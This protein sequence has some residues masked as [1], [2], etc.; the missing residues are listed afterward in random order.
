[1]TTMKDLVADTRRIAYGSMS[2]QLNF[3]SA[4]T[5]AGADELFMT[6]DLGAIAP[7]MVLSCGLNVYY[8]TGA[9]AAEKK[10][11]VYPG[12]DNSPTGILTA[13]SPVMIRP[14]V[15][16]WLLFNNVN[17]VI[18]QMSSSTFGLYREASWDATVDPTWQTYP[19]P[20]VAQSMTALIK[21]Q[22]RYPGSDDTWID[23]PANSVQWQPENNLVRM[24]RGYPSGTDMRFFYRAAFV[25]GVSLTTDV[26]VTCGLAASMTDIPPLGAA[27]ALLRTTESR[28]SQ[29]HAQGD[30][31]RSEEVVAMG[32]AQAAREL[33]RDFKSRVNDEYIRLLNRNPITRTI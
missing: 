20:T 25:E 6:M 19:I 10:V 1:M 4:D 3:L 16:D 21:V 17:D 24:T 28:R 8:V 7:G 33:D 5:T 18:R 15:T 13:G 12:Y 32:N 27:V 22:I 2:D 14:R 31:R 23:L 11:M 9:V 30:P 26:V 29:I